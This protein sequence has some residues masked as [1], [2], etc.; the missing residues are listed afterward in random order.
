MEFP[1]TIRRLREL[2][3]ARKFKLDTLSLDGFGSILTF[4][5][6]DINAF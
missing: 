2:C 5:E 3:D 1:G 6:N 4:S